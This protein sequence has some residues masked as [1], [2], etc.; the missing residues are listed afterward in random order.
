PRE[1]GVVDLAVRAARDPIRSRAAWRVEHRHR[2][3]L[4]VEP[5]EHA[6]LAGEPQHAAI[7]VE[8]R[9]VETR[10]ASIRR[11]REALDLAREWIN[12]D[13]RVQ[14]AVGD[15][16]RTIGTDDHAVGRGP[17][18]ELDRLRLAGLWIEPAKLARELRR[19]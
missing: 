17:G 7:L 16:R 3:A 10:V 18:A 5:T 1:R 4:R 19:V 6:T 12:T 15:P 13:D 8:H 9:R 11:Q 2:T 14:T